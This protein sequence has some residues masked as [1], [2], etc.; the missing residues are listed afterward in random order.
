MKLSCMHLFSCMNAPLLL[1]Y[2]FS[3]LLIM[4]VPGS[5][6]TYELCLCRKDGSTS[7]ATVTLALEYDASSY[8]NTRCADT[9]GTSRA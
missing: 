6:I 2:I 1:W 8:A 9:H 4:H 3:N 7:T 5:H